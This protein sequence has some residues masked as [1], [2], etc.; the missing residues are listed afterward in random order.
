MR[1]GRRSGRRTKKPNAAYLQADP[2]SDHHLQ[3]GGEL[4]HDLSDEGGDGV[5]VVGLVELRLV[6]AVDED[7]EVLLGADLPLW[8]ENTRT[9]TC[10]KIDKNDN[11][12][13]LH[14]RGQASEGSSR[15]NSNIEKDMFCDLVDIASL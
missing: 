7:D 2:N 14:F 11:R 15:N 10:W 12:M 13:K 3:P 1:E 5:P 6:E 8:G 9:E 4:G